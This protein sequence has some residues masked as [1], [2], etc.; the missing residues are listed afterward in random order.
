M[1]CLHLVAVLLNHALRFSIN[2]V[3]D[4]IVSHIVDLSFLGLVPLIV[5]ARVREI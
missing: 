2:A 1:H 5:L 4:G 3:L